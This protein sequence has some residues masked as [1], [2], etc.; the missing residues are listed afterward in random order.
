M[1]AGVAGAAAVFGLIFI[2]SP[3]NGV[4]SQG[5]LPGEPG[6][7][8]GVDH[9]EGVLRISRASSAGDEIVATAR[10]GA[11]GL[12]RDEDD[13]PI[14]R[15]VGGDVVIDPDALRAATG[16]E[17]STD[18][19]RDEPKLCPDPSAENVNGRKAFDVQYEQYIRGLVNP[20]RQPPLPPGLAFSLVNPT[21][22]RPVVFD[23][24]RES[25]GAMIEAKGHYEDMLSSKWG[26]DKLAEDWPNQAKRQILASGGRTVEW[27]FHEQSAADYARDLFEEDVVLKR[28]IINVEPDPA[29]V[30]NPNPRIK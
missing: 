28:I 23:D 15:A 17:A 7:A 20:Q 13:A 29:G 10:L 18:A 2:P 25:D 22:G 16:A 5:Q 14:A 12:F 24:C 6:L 30:P 21:T 26:R 3:N 8:Y 1:A 19:S 11:D 9:D 27:Y 4:V